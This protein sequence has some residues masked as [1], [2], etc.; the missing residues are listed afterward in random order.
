MKN[1]IIKIATRKSALALWQAEFVKKSLE[2][3]HPDLKIELVGITTEGDQKIDTALS[4]IGGKGLFIKELE[5]ALLEGRADIAV[6]SMKD[7]PAELPDGFLLGAICKREDP[8][9][10]FVSNRY[11]SL[12]HLPKGAKVGTSSLR[13]QSQIKSIRADLKMEILRGN[14]NTRLQRLDEGDFS[15]I[16]LASAGL[17]RLGFGF[18]VADY[19]SIEQCLPAAGQGAIGIECR[20]IDTEILE[21]IK[22]LDDFETRTCLSAEREMNRVLEGGCQVPIA[23]YATI[24]NKQLTLQGMVGYPDGSLLLRG[25]QCGPQEK[26]LE[27]GALLAHELIEKGAKNIIKTCYTE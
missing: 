13:R 17:L 4:K 25:I 12:D 2:H 21:K 7:I 8:R 27:L 3:Y 18:R 24:K 23:A 22:Y 19:L 11:S 1:N 14:V 10:A 6:H 16:I 9:D 26:A 15:A 20:E 5:H